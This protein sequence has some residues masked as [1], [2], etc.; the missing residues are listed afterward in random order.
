LLFRQLMSGR[1]ERDTRKTVE[2][3]VDVIRRDQAAKSPA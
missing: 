1:V 3:L 2:N